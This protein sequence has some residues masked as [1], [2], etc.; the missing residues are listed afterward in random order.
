M[1]DVAAHGT[2]GRLGV[3]CEPL[4]NFEIGAYSY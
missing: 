2:R 4:G 3:M 1:N